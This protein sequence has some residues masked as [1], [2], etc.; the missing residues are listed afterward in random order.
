VKDD[1]RSYSTVAQRIPRPSC[2]SIQVLSGIFDST[3]DRSMWISINLQSGHS[4][5]PNVQLT[6]SEGAG[7][8]SP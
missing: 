8:A 1:Q 6:T 5:M 2:S 4:T 7:V 3:R